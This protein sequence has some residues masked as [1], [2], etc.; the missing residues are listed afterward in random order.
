MAKG[1]PTG[2]EG[3]ILIGVCLGDYIGL[4][5]MQERFSIRTLDNNKDSL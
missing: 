2:I 3:D 1:A 4:N 5:G